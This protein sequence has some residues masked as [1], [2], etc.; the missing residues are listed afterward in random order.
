MLALSGF[1]PINSLESIVFPEPL[2]PIIMRVS[3][4][5]NVNEISFRIVLLSILTFSVFIFNFSIIF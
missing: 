3:P 4:L 5:G 1:I 2:S